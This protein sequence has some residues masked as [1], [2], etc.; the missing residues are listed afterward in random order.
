M[1]LIR[2]MMNDV[3]GGITE[4]FMSTQ[5]HQ[6]IMRMFRGST[7]GTITSPWHQPDASDQRA[8]CALPLWCVRL[9]TES[10]CFPFLNLPLLWLMWFARPFPSMSLLGWLIFSH[11]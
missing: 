7:A 11:L 1:R 8:R 2:L 6:P 10:S 4:V 9:D 3:Q 5:D